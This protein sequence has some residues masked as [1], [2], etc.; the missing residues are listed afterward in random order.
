MTILDEKY[1]VSDNWPTPVVYRKIQVAKPVD[2]KDGEGL[3]MEQNN[4]V[5]GKDYSAL[6][7]NLQAKAK[8][9]KFTET[10]KSEIDDAFLVAE[11]LATDSYEKGL[12]IEAET[13]QSAR[14]AL[15]TG[16]SLTEDQVN[17]LLGGM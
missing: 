13:R 15:L 5:L 16:E 10:P 2:E 9:A 11:K 6:P 17:L 14:K 4:W 3:T 8:K 12:S 7:E 1:F